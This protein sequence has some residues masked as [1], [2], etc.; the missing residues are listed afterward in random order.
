[1]RKPCVVVIVLACLLCVLTGC[2]NRQF[3]IGSTTYTTYKDAN[4]YS[5]GSFNYQSDKVRKVCIDYVFGDVTLV[6]SSNRTLNVTEPA[7]KLSDD[8]KVHW[9]LDGSTLYIRFCKSGYI[10][11]FPDNS[12][13]ISIE[14]PFGIELE[15]GI[16]SGDVKFATDVEATEVSLGATSGDFKV[17]TIRT[18]NFQTGCTSG[19]IHIDALY[20]TKASFGSTS[21]NTE[22]DLIQAETIKFGSTSGNTSLGNI[23]AHEVSGAGT[24]GNIIL[25]FGYCEKLEIGCTSGNVRIEKLPSNGATITYEKT[26]GSLKAD[27]YTVKGG[28]MVYGDGGCEMK[29]VTTSGDLTIN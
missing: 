24:S 9:Y 1:M 8:Q 20:A 29:I 22:V 26:S 28:K 17:K 12:K 5:V 25:S 23:N 10:G 7:G 16:T 13:K 2:F 27:N 15:V 11:T 3:K 18:G 6:Q 4:K 19:N 21:G 14:I